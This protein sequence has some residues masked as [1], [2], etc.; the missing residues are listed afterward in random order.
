L[1]PAERRDEQAM[2]QHQDVTDQQ[3]ESLHLLI[4]DPE[5]RKDGRGRPWKNRRE[6]LNGILYVLRTGA[7]WADLPERYP[8][9]QTC[10]RRFQHWTRSGVMRDV[11]GALGEDLTVGREL[12]GVAR[13]G[14]VRVSA[15]SASAEL[16]VEQASP[17]G[18]A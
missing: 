4:P 13:L 9:Y 12:A 17:A 14:H 15:I 10:H 2:P 11:L 6:V 16:M 8:P 18:N 1:N 7:A 3:W 5:R